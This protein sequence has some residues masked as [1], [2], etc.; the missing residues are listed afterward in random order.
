MGLYRQR[1]IGLITL[2][3]LILFH[4]YNS[5]KVSLAFDKPDLYSV[6]F[7]FLSIL[8]P[9]YMVILNDIAFPFKSMKSIDE[10]KYRLILDNKPLTFYYL[11]HI[12]KVF[13]MLLIVFSFII[14]IVG[15]VIE[16][17]LK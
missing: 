17:I 8:L 11:K 10:E 12:V 1:I 14:M 9:L 3:L 15:F 13:L 7:I 4:F 5:V 2:A 6:G 16:R